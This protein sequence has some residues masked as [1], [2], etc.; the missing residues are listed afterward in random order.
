MPD[1]IELRLKPLRD[2]IDRVDAQLVELLNERARL[3]A[4]VGRVKGE[5]DAP[6]LRTEREAEVLRK[7]TGLSRGPLTAEPLS[8]VFREI[9]SACRALERPLTVAFLGPTGTFSE[10][11]MHRQFGTSVTGLPCATLDEVFRATEAGSAE[12]GIVPLENSTEGAVSRTLDLLLATP[13]KLM[14]ELSLTVDHNLLTHS[15]TMDGIQCIGAHAQALAQCAGWLAQHYP[16]I[17]RRPV[18]SNAE[19]A[20]LAAEDPA[21]AAIAGERAAHNYQLSAVATHIQDDPNNRTRFAVL[22]RQAT[23]PSVPPGRDKTSLIL[24]VPNKAGAVFHMLEPL[25]RHGVSM[26]RFESRP[27]RVGTWEYYFYVDIEGHLSDP[28]VATALGEL[29]RACAFYKCLG[30]YPAER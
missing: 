29:Q 4:E 7:V 28:T 15:G 5:V 16:A 3:A 6:V 2:A 26:L 12:V 20:R 13:L 23:R 14:A 30:S 21:F 8:N 22:G 11:A 1:A 19:A 17:E 10:A 18:A 27:A 24:S 25:A 9:M